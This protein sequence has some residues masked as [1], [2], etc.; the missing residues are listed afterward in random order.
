MQISFILTYVCEPGFWTKSHLEMLQWWCRAWA[1]FWELAN[2]MVSWWWEKRSPSIQTVCIWYVAHGPETPGC[3]L[4]AREREKM[5]FNVWF[6]DTNCISKQI[7][8][9]NNM[10][11]LFSLKETAFSYHCE[12]NKNNFELEK[13]VWEQALTFHVLYWDS[14]RSEASLPGLG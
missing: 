10:I 5:L 3:A 14:P 1:A 8:F 4:C 12:V 7:C 13:L 2:T 11:V 9:W 6:L